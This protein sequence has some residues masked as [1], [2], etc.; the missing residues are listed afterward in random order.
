MHTHTHTHIN[1]HTH[2][3]TPIH[4]INTLY[5]PRH[6]LSIKLCC[7]K[8]TR[9][10]FHC[11][12]HA[13]GPGHSSVLAAPFPRYICNTI[14]CIDTVTEGM[15]HSMA[16]SCAGMLRV[17]ALVMTPSQQARAARCAQNTT[18]NPERMMEAT[19]CLWCNYALHA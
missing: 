18:V 19:P 10:I 3:Y 15:V 12:I 9:S 7:I 17:G 11:C 2:P 16:C 4:A 6:N 1:M 13:F 14:V 5:N 8:H